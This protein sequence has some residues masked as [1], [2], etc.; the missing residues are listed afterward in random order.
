MDIVSEFDN[1]WWPSV[2]RR[3][4]ISEVPAYLSKMVKSFLEEGRGLEVVQIP[5]RLELVENTKEMKR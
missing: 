2:Y 3:L 1:I 5:V 4:S